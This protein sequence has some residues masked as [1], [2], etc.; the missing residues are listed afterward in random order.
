M[1]TKRD[2]NAKGKRTNFNNDNECLHKQPNE[3][4]HFEES[5]IKKIYHGLKLKSEDIII[6]EKLV[7]N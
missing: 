1:I 3:S 5:L 6:K 4:I 2:T 7:I